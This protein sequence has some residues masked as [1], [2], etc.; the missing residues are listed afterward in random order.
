MSS[1]TTL[2]RPLRRMS[3]P[4][5]RAQLLEVTRTIV[6]EEG[7]HAV[8]IEAV[9]RRAGVS[10]PIVYE[11]FGDLPGLLDA[12]IDRLGATALAQLAVVLPGDLGSGETP[13]DALLAALRG[14]LEAVQADPVT[15]RLVLMPPEGAP[16]SAGERIAS[17]RAQVVAQLA[18]AVAPGVAGG[19]VP[20]PELTAWLLATVA[21]EMARLVLTEPAVYTLDR[22]L[23][24]A[25]WLLERTEP[26][27]AFR[28]R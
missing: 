7:F 1:M 27:A 15:W 23:A 2:A 25:A 8:T 16:R 19:E 14:Y 22:L 21:D 26:G 10:R 4:E 9:A 24:H 5:R 17:G 11:H 18:A 28:A 20:D 12:L 6:A 13:R 3:A